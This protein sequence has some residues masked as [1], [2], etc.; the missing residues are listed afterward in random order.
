[1]VAARHLMNG[2]CLAMPHLV[3]SRSVESRPRSIS[4]T[5]EPVSGTTRL[6]CY[7]ILL[8]DGSMLKS[9]KPMERSR[10]AGQ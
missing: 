8:G 1:M 9:G 6:R 7:T 3:L 10:I 4:S 5:W 2:Q